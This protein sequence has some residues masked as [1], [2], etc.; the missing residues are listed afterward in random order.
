LGPKSYLVDGVTAL[1]FSVDCVCRKPCLLHE[2]PCL[3]QQ[4]RTLRLSSPI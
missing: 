3:R 2:L 4:R 1:E